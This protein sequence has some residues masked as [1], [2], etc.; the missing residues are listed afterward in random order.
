MIEN[1]AGDGQGTLERVVALVR[2]LR[3]RCEWDRRQTRETLRPYL[4]EEILELD[5][6]IATRDASAVDHE[7]GDVLLHLAW[8]LVLNEEEGLATG[9]ELASAVVDRMQRRHPHLFALGDREPWEV[10]KQREHR[11]SVLA[12]LPRR[13]P[14]LLAAYRLQQRA[15]SVGFDWPD[16]AGPIAKIREEIGEVERA[17]A[18]SDGAAVA[19]ELGDLMFACVNLARKLGVDPGHALEQANRKFAR[20]FQAVEREAG[21]QGIALSGAG[22]EVLDALWDAVKRDEQ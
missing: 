7:L 14:S 2:D 4:V 1:S 10:L 15:A 20:R 8:Q 21:A 22:L 18:G 19:D 17:M 13:L 9:S 11:G 6:A 3:A 5:E 12:G 16:A